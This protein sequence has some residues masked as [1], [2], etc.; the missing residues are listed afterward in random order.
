MIKKLKTLLYKIIGK[1]MSNQTDTINPNIHIEEYLF[2]YLM[3]QNPEYA[4]L[5]NG[6]W[7]SGKTH[8]MQTFTDCTQ[9]K[10]IKFIKISLFGLKDTNS[11]DEEIFQNLHP[12]LGSKYAKLTGNILKGALKLG[13]NVDWNQDDIKDG[14]ATID[15]NK[16]NPLDFFSDNKKSKQ[17]IIFI[18]DDLE[19]TGIDLKEILGYINYLVEQS[20]FK[21]IILANEEKINDTEY[22]EFKEKIIGKTFEVKH[23]FDD[24]LISFINSK[25]KLS[26]EI[27]IINTQII[28]DNY[29]K[30]NYNNLRH[31]S[32]IL[33]DFEYF[34][35]NINEEYL[36]DKEFV[37]IL[38]N[39][40]F[41]LSIELKSANLTREELLKKATIS[42]DFS[43]NKDKEKT[44]IE[45]IYEKYNITNNPLFDGK[46]WV[47]IL[48]DNSIQKE[49]LD[50]LISNL[51]FFL[52]KKEQNQPSWVKVW[53]YRQLS[54]EEFKTN[55]S[56]VLNKFKNCEYDIPEHLMHVTA[57]LIFFS[58]NKLC[59]ISIEEIKSLIDTCISNKYKKNVNW[60]NKLFENSMRFNGT[61]L[62]YMDGED[63]DFREIFKQIKEENR[64]IYKTEE[65]DKQ[66]KLLKQF[67]K[68]IETL[69]EDFLTDLLLDKYKS[70]PL[71]NQLDDIE[72][73]N[74]LTN[75][76]NKNISKLSE[77]LYSRYGDH[78]Y[79]ND[80]LSYCY[81][82]DELNFWKTVNINLSDYLKSDKGSNT[83][84]T[85]LLHQF[86]K[87]LIEN[88]IE[89]LES[90]LKT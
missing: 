61:G 31:I 69:N 40:F 56:D 57:L 76:E 36:K 86:N 48:L 88:I 24:I 32:Q 20:N 9:Q 89:K 67:L 64:T 28:K 30:A 59:K 16:F 6:K 51:S 52:V 25:T 71:F 22:K 33:Y 7:G 8:F 80:R 66:Q 79:I 39:N 41:A 4:I 37:S 13:V 81:L 77:I 60:K 14:T 26:K 29:E 46:T 35:K 15:L 55:L 53:H 45:K 17:E 85:F 19:R 75:L 68:S 43:N 65:I 62:G 42:W 83:L 5:L 10:N 44:N 74:I 18:F 21:V 1:K 63:K 70:I 72:F 50:K 73:V 47:E 87:Y 3:L 12:L 23:F 90:C 11:I 54:N 34:I 78:Y 2:N 84:K 58:K 82:T 38:I 27:L 49:E